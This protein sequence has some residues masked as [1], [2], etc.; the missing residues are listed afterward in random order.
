MTTSAVQP[1]KRREIICIDFE[2]MVK[3]GQLVKLF[4][5]YFTSLKDNIAAN[6]V[7]YSSPEAYY[8][9]QLVYDAI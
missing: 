9:A 4:K 7:T 6:Q 5:G 3:N 2:S 8:L 1:G